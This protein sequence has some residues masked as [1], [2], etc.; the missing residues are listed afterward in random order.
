MF[1]NSMKLINRLISKGMSSTYLKV[2]D[3]KNWRS[4]N[5]D[6][7][8]LEKLSPDRFLGSSN[9][10]THHWTLKLLNQKSG[11]KTVVGFSI[12]LVLKE[13]MMF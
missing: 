12:I 8:S 13:I 7:L 9:S 6:F 11:T 5:F 2:T 1:F 10:H 3:K 4:Q